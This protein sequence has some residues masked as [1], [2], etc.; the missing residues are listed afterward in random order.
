MRPLERLLK[1][2]IRSI[3][4]IRRLWRPSELNPRGHDDWG[5]LADTDHRF[6]QRSEVTP[7]VDEKSVE[8]A[9]IIRRSKGNVLV[10]DKLYKHGSATSI[11]MKVRSSWGRQR[12]IARNSWRSLRQ[13]CSIKDASWESIQ[14]WVLLAN[15]F[16]WR[17]RPPSL[18]HQ[19]LVL[20]Q[21]GSCPGT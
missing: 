17:R 9:R 4:S 2:V 5:W 16:G 3:L 13:S 7:G 10:G 8:A 12:N 19:L 18:V 11:L 21:T 6:H 1:K 14:V 20:W 15:S